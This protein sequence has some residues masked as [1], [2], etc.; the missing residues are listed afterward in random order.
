MP[1]IE[2]YMKN[3]A[4]NQEQVEVA[5]ILAGGTVTRKEATGYRQAIEVAAESYDDE[6]ASKYPNL[7][8]EW[9]NLIGQVIEADKR[10]RHEGILYKCLQEH[11]AQSD[12]TPTTA[13]SLFTKVLIPDENVIPEW[14][15][16]DST[17][18]Y[19]IGDKVTHNGKTWESTTDNNVWEPGVYGWETV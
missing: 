16:P 8:P 9:K 19:M 15:Q 14:E 4:N 17:N 18:P 13:P 3:A 6:T 2:E 10:V 5:K 7:Y 11:T 1:S 12:W